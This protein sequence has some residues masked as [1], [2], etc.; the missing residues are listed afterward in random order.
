MGKTT[1]FSTAGIQLEFETD[2]RLLKIAVCTVESNPHERNFYS[3]DIYSN[4]KM[5]G[6]IKNFKKSPKYPYK[7]YSLS[8]KQKIVN[9]P[10]GLKRICIYFPWSVQGLIKEIELD[11]NATLT[12]VTK[13]KK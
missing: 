9:F 10:T 4:G 1:V 6:Q 2:S 12:P 7:R 5:I 3:F 11:D 13:H 8:D